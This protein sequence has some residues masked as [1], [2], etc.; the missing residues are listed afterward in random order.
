MPQFM[1]LLRDSPENKPTPGASNDDMFEQMMAWARK[2]DKDNRLRSVAPLK[3][4]PARTLYPNRDQL[5]VVDG[6]F[7]EGKEVVV[8]YF[9]VEANNL[10]EAE[11]IAR[12]CPAFAGGMTGI[13]LR[14]LAGFP[15]KS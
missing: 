9:I 15:F 6:P 13:E 14:E 2:L 3:R 1:L 5:A 11:V 12:Q 4:S 8:G 10:V 7:T